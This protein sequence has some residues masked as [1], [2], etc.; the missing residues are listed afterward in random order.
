MK[1]R[2]VFFVLPI[3]LAGAYLG[4]TDH[5]SKKLYDTKCASCHGKDLKGNATMAKMFK[6]E[7][8]L[9]DLTTSVTGAKSDD[10]LVKLTTKGVGKM[11][12]YEKSLKPTEIMGLVKYIRSVT[13]QKTQPK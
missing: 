3:F 11:P 5:P 2:F 6:V 8:S 1:F 7:P 4:A 13:P 12:G 9:M 10:E